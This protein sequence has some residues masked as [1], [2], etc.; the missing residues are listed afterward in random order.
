MRWCGAQRQGVRPARELAAARWQNVPG[1]MRTRWGRRCNRKGG[2]APCPGRPR[3]IE[4]HGIPAC[5]P[6]RNRPAGGQG[7]VR[8]AGPGPSGAALGD[9]GVQ[10]RGGS[11]EGGLPRR[12]DQG[13][14]GGRAE[15]DRGRD[16]RP[17]PHGSA[18]QG[19]DHSGP[20]GSRSSF[21]RADQL[22]QECWRFC[23]ATDRRP[24]LRQTQTRLAL[25]GQPLCD[26]CPV[27]DRHVASVGNGKADDRMPALRALVRKPREHPGSTPLVDVNLLRFVALLVR[28]S[29][30]ERG[31]RLSASR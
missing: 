20:A 24:L 3:D 16:V 23:F 12:Q 1:V 11:R 13:R 22:N 4:R 2:V 21:R 15:D 14:A 8:Q 9:Q 19:A 5:L 17:W 6:V 10:D 31:C 26:D 18:P 29:S 25:P 7:Q 27:W 28:A 30:V